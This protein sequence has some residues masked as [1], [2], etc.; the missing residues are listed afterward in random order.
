MV[1]LLKKLQ[2]LGPP[3]WQTPSWRIWIG[4]LCTLGLAALLL[5]AHELGIRVPNPILFFANFVVLSAFLGGQRASLVSIGLT[6]IFAL[7]YWSVPHHVFTYSQRDISR[8]I[9]LV[10]TIPPLGLLV[11]RLRAAHDRS[12]QQLIGQ[13]QQL[14]HELQRRTALEERQRDV[15]HILRH[16][17]R[18]PL[19]GIINIPGLM[20]EDAN[21]TDHQRKLLAMIAAAGRKML[22]QINS[23]L[24]LHKIEEDAYSPEIAVC[25]PAAMLRDNYSILTLCDAGET[26][27]LT[28]I[29]DTPVSLKTD[30][31]LLDVILANLLRNALEA[32]D[33][34]APV[35][36]RLEADATDCVISI[37]NSQPVPEEIRPRFF[38]KYATSGKSGGTGLGTYSAQLM[39]RALGGTITMHTSDTDGTII[40]VRL[41]VNRE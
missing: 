17:L 34:G 23:S 10:L 39:T 7:L 32:S 30:C 5:A 40:T 27:P 35:V 41:P 18:S 1:T 22:S 2:P 20:L 25:T 33:P 6:L 21:L 16:D 31:R 9:V 26:T 8:L 3:Y 37:A 12:E 14:S 19:G 24:E 36:A 13:N 38:E 29:E 11:G 4:P 28:L 15:E